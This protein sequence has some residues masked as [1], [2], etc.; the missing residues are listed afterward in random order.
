MQTNAR[1]AELK[2]EQTI[3]ES[4]QLQ[5][6][7]ELSGNTQ[8]A[9]VSFLKNMRHEVYNI[10]DQDLQEK[11]CQNRSYTQKFMEDEGDSFMK[12]C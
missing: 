12:K 5:G 3:H 1:G 9:G 8:Q 7:V 11:L 6:V 10:S 2:R 4:T